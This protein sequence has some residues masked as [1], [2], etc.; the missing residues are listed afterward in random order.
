MKS[1]YLVSN[2]FKYPQN[3]IHRV[4]LLIIKFNFHSGINYYHINKLKGKF[5]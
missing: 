2:F 3:H 5:I 4:E 1:N